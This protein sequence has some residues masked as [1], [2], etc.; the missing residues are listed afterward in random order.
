MKHTN[1][2]L[3]SF[4]ASFF[5]I[6]FLP[7]MPGTWGSAAAFGLYLLLPATA[8]SGAGL[9]YTLPIFAIFC[10][11]AVYVSGKAEL[12]LGHDSGHIVIDE[13]C[14]YFVAVMF[15]PQ[16][17]LVGLYAF[18]FF[19]VFDIAKPFPISRSQKLPK[20]WGV[21]VDDLLAG[22]FANVLTQII[23]RIYPKFFGL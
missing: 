22:L 19:R 16:T 5:G 11:F 23:I 10:L 6:G 7:K 2:G 18:L 21:V 1:P 14:G 4:L 3:Y 9:L 20:G 17:L 15:L 8:F 12:K 13:V